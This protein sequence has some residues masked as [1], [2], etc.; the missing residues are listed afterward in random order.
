[1]RIDREMLTTAKTSGRRLQGKDGLLFNLVAAAFS[2]IYLYGSGV[3]LLPP[4]Y[5]RG[6]YVLFTMLLTF[7]GYPA[8]SGR[9][10]DSRP[11]A[12]DYFLFLVALATFGYWIA[13]YPNYAEFRVSTPNVWD[14]GFGV[15]GILLVLEMTRRVL[16]WTLPILAVL[17]LA[18][19]YFGPY[20]PGTLSH[21]GMEIKRIV[22]F[23]FS[24][25]GAIFGVVTETF[26]TFVFSFIILGAFFEKSGAGTFFIELATALTGRW[27]GGPAKIAVIASGL[28]GSIS[29]SS[30]AN[31]VG[32]GAFTIPMMK[33]IGF[34]P[35]IAGAIEAIASTG[36]Q[37]MPPVMGAGVFILATITEESYLKIA[38]MNIIPALLYFLFVGFMV[39][40][41]ALKSGLRSMP[42]EELP[43]VWGTLKRGWHFFIPLIIVMVGLF[44]GRTPEMGAYWA[45]VATT[46]LSWLR[47]DTRMS[48]ND[49]FGALA[50]GGKNNVSAGSAIPTLGLIMGGIVLAGLGLKFSAILVS[51]AGGSL[52][53]AIILVCFISTLVG[54]GATTTGSYIILSV[55]AAPALIQLGVPKVPAHLVVFWTATFSNVTPPVCV[56]AYA[57]ASI[58][59]A[60]PVKTGLAALKYGVFLFVVPFSF[61]Y[62]PEILLQ[63]SFWE[64]V[65][66]TGR[67][68]LFIYALAAAVQGVLIRNLAWIPRLSLFAAAGL[69]FF[70]H[71]LGDI[72]GAALLAG[73]FWLQRRSFGRMPPAAQPMF[74]S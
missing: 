48:A 21:S 68:L 38:V 72:A 35:H 55:V 26:A 2:L 37:F 67:Y 13:E 39:D 11:S 28:F 56:S 4:Q 49:I 63:G 42:A 73:N 51:L 53:F 12:V 65:H 50:L 14:L 5:N 66:I 33:R 52:F 57:A 8:R 60:D 27:R 32:T 17:F 30:V 19:L 45:V 16:G 1:M 44:T 74:R 15:V 6:C 62:F 22:E 46:V 47:K 24:T 25:M 7:L 18:Q 36:G 29:G 31:V 10:P 9:S 70:P 71:F 40:F 69:L 41:E 54:M 3:G 59:E 58:A 64:V 34:R 23:S 20:L 61:V 43:S